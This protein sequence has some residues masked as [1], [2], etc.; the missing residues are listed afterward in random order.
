MSIEPDD[1]DYI[2]TYPIRSLGPDR[3]VI[4]VHSSPGLQCELRLTNQPSKTRHLFLGI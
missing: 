4:K 1:D 2:C 3:N